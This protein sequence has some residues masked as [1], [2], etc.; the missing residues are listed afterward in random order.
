MARCEICNETVISGLVVHTECLDRAIILPVPIG[1]KVYVPYRY[2]ELDESVDEG[3]EEYIITGYIKEHDKAFYTVMTIDSNATDDIPCDE[4]YTT[5]AA[6]EKALQEVQPDG[7][8][9]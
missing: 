6:A 8:N 4:V 9:I 1:E 3:V 2:Q 7:S 5:Q